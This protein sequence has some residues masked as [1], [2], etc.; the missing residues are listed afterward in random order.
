[1]LVLTLYYYSIEKWGGKSD[2]AGPVSPGGLKMLH[3]LLAKAVAIY[4]QVNIIK[5]REMSFEELF[6]KIRPLVLC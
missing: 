6:A 1:M 2:I 3:T 5:V 4:I